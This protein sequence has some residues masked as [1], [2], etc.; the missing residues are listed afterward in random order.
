[1]KKTPTLL[2]LLVSSLLHAQ[3][4]QQLSVAPANPTSLDSVR[5]I[6]D[7]MFFSGSCELQQSTSAVNGNV[8]DISVYH[9]PGLLTF[10]CYTSDTITLPPLT[11]GSYT[12]NFNVLAGTYD[13][14]TGNCTNYSNGGQQSL[15][16]IVTGTNHINSVSLQ[17][18]QLYFEDDK[19]TIVL[20]GNQKARVRIMDITG[21]TLFDRS[22]PPGELPIT[23][24][25]G[26]L[27]YSVQLPDGSVKSGRLRIQ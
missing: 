7:L 11:P 19:N 18:S 4:L 2:L 5:I 16:F 24:P 10:I 25:T 3:H 12:V 20:T 15:Q 23:P 1:M 21:R 14:N 6:G 27:V 17:P 8:I 22:T 9:C 26:L 13:F